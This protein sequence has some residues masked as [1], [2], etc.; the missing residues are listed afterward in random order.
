MMIVPNYCIM[1][2]YHTAKIKKLSQNKL[3]ANLK[4]LLEQFI[5]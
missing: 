1:S 4:L 3:A 5:E 2:N